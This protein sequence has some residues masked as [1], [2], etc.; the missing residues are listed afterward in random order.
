MRWTILTLA[1][2]GPLMTAPAR[3]QD[4]GVLQMQ[5]AEAAKA[6]VDAFNDR[7]WD[8]TFHLGDEAP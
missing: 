4:P 8:R 5:V 6:F 1:A 2:L 3:G 7:D